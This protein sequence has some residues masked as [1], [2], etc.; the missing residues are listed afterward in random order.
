MNGLFNRL[1]MLVLIGNVACAYQAPTVEEV[2]GAEPAPLYTRE[3]YVVSGR[4]AESVADY[5]P[6]S[7][8]PP[9]PGIKVHKG[10]R[11]EEGASLALVWMGTVAG[12]GLGHLA[13][14]QRAY[15]ERGWVFS[16]G[17]A[18]SVGLVIWG[19][20]RADSCRERDGRQV[21]GA[22]AWPALAGGLAF[23]GFKIWEIF[24][25]VPRIDGWLDENL[26]TVPSQGLMLLPD[27]QGAAHL[28]YTW[29]F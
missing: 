2:P 25:M 12:F 10:L 20:T 21:C 16:V 18:A 8:E 14:S 9:P 5:D 1:L 19:V 6:E 11:T 15:A 23:L 27:Q 28:A 24:D 22:D 3:G 26:E 4:D 29:R 13:F 7:G 17:Q